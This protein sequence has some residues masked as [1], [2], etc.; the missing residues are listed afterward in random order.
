[1]QTPVVPE[2]ERQRLDALRSLALLDTPAE[3]R[4]DRLTRM[5]RNM[6]DVPIALVSL[7]DEN[8]QWFKS[9]CGLSVLETSRDISFCG[10]AI[11]GDALF[12]VE[13][14]S[15]DPR[16][17]DN[18][19]VTGEPYIRFYAGHP[20]DVGNGLK[21]G[22]LRIIDC[23]PRVFGQREQA[24]LSDLAS[25]AESE[26]KAI[27]MATMDELTGLTNRRGFMLLAERN[28][29]YAFRA[30]IPASLL[31]IDLNH[32]KSINDRFGH[33]VGD[34]ALCQMAELLCK[35]FRNADIIARLG[36]DEF[37]V[38]LSGTSNEYCSG[39]QARFTQALESF[40]TNNGKPYQ[41][42]CSMGIVGYDATTAPD[43][44]MLLRLADDEMY[45]CKKT[46][47]NG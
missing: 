41:L 11:L 44:N 2:N 5:A 21:L 27:H 40:N 10:H 34:D 9:C 22:T 45:I 12:V 19:L 16:F 47:R 36:G 7:V 3:E 28:L 46:V 20:L 39:I 38:L 6:F 23:K 25:M 4:F 37:V 15:Q 24:L 35:M 29:Q 30:K 13:D 43:I 17:A 18:P 8:R 1:M 14:A 31:F 33:D 42:S 32:F 26:L